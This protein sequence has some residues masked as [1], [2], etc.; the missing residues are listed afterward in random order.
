MFLKKER[1]NL[2][3]IN[4]N[5]F[6]GDIKILSEPK[7]S[8]SNSVV[9]YNN[10]NGYGYVYKISP[11]NDSIKA[12][13]TIY[14]RLNQLIFHK[15]CP[16]LFLTFGSGEITLPEGESKL[17]SLI[18]KVQL[19]SGKKYYCQVN[20]TGPDT[21]LIMP[22]YMLYTKKDNT[23][24]QTFGT[25]PFLEDKK[26]AVNFI[27]VFYNLLFQY[28]WV[29]YVFKL[30]AFSQ[31]DTH[32]GNIM[33]IFNKVNIFDTPDDESLMPDKI[34]YR[35]YTFSF[36]VDNDGTNTKYTKTYYLEDLGID[37]YIYDFDKG[38]FRNEVND[39]Q[40]ISLL[41]FEH[42]RNIPDRFK[43]IHKK[44]NDN[45]KQDNDNDKVDNIM[46]IL[47]TL[48]LIEQSNHLNTLTVDANMGEYATASS[49]MYF[50]IPC[51]LSNV[52]HLTIYKNVY[53][54]LSDNPETDIVPE[55]IIKGK[56]VSYTKK[57]DKNVN[58]H[59]P[60]A[61]GMESIKKRVYAAYSTEPLKNTA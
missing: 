34:K 32:F 36:D 23:G 59:Y 21:K 24:K 45:G 1:D 57:D 4:E 50:Y 52:Q 35:S 12:E 18:E 48:P 44:N 56:Y 3:S 42:I 7:D 46:Q 28:C 16:H 31:G 5:L 39:E 43:S 20:E 51:I 26:K 33:L 38:S 49:F 10:H 37:L 25:S 27:R 40:S 47:K 22:F 54:L 58:A 17:K 9:L 53:M 6:A 14:K 13:A 2:F 60:T 29:M 55:Q 8:A 41:K 19:P 15:V 61:E 11:N 30:I